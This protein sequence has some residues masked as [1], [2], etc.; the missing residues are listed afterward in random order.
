MDDPCAAW[1]ASRELVVI[2]VRPAGL[3]AQPDAD[4]GRRPGL[5]HAG[6][7][8][9]TGDQS[10]VSGH[11]SPPSGSASYLASDVRGRSQYPPCRVLR[12][13]REAAG[14]EAPEL[15]ARG[16]GSRVGGSESQFV[17]RVDRLA[18]STLVPFGL[19]FRES[20]GD[21]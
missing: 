18:G 15:V 12:T 19:Y 3:E 2:G 13:G 4:A 7:S 9:R 6:P 5:G 21:Y 17:A 10:M 16:I 1:I 11:L 14:V 8:E 20:E